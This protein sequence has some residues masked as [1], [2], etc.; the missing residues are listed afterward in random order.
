MKRDKIF[1][2][3]STGL[4]SAAFLMSG[5]MYLSGA[6]QIIDG[7]KAI[8]FP[9]YFVPFLGIA[10]ISGALALLN[11]WFRGLKE[12]AYAGITINLL[13]A[14]WA[15]ISTQTPFATILVFLLVLAVSYFF[16][17]RVQQ[18]QELKLS[19]VKG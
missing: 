19:T 11:P 10:K 9:L 12:W 13:G 15:H 1:Y 3:I 5:S 14:A 4:V 16:H 18:Q 8:G 2:W 6:P 17:T 7:F